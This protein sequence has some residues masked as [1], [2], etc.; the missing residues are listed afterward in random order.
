MF[1][2]IPFPSFPSLP[3]PSLPSFLPSFPSFLPFL[4][5]LPSFLPSLPSFPSFPI[6]SP[7]ACPYLY[8]IIH[9]SSVPQSHVREKLFVFNKNIK[10]FLQTS[11]LN[12]SPIPKC[13]SQTIKKGFGWVVFKEWIKHWMCD[14][15]KV[16]M[17]QI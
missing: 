13:F 12:I 16:Y 1:V 8:E 5:S 7:H 11:I 4:P 14:N 9:Q 2:N 6:N 10:F 17:W 15:G 3:F